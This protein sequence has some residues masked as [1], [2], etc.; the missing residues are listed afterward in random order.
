MIFTPVI[1]MD[2][3]QGEEHDYIEEVYRKYSRFMFAAAWKYC[4]SRQGV[5]EI[6]SDSC[7]SFIR[8]IETM[9]SLHENSLKAYIVTTIKNTAINYSNKQRR[10]NINEIYISEEVKDDIPGTVDVAHKIAL[11][12]ELRLVLAA[13]ESLPENEKQIMRMKYLME[14][15]DDEIAGQ[16]GI[17]VNSIR[18]YVSRARQKIRKMV[19]SEEE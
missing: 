14:M 13:I 16:V 15:S 18:K 4:S 7:L 1:I 5:E 10:Q 17:S 6:V 2:M 3:P 9:R 19:Y 12:D 8:N 11:L